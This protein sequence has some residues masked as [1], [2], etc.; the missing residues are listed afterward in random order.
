[1][2]WGEGV[3]GKCRENEK[4]LKTY[5]SP[6]TL[7]RLNYATISKCWR[8]RKESTTET[9]RDAEG[10]RNCKAVLREKLRRQP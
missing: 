7:K 5:P 3:F 2:R 6:V 10:R 4:K 9:R 1:M 8:C